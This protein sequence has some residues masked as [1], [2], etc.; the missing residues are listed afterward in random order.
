MSKLSER[1]MIAHVKIESWSAKCKD[2]KVTDKVHRDHNASAD[3]GAYQKRLLSK[4]ALAEITQI[5]NEAR[6]EHYART[7]PWE[8]GGMRLLS[9]AGFTAYAEAMKGYRRKFECAVEKFVSLY[10]DF[11]SDARARLNGMFNAA[12]YPDPDQIHKRFGFA[13][14]INPVPES[15]D[16]RVTLSDAQAAEIRADIEARTRDALADGMRDVWERVA[17]RVGHMAKK[18]NEF[19]PATEPG[20]KNQGV[21]RDSLVEN[22]RELVRLLP[23]LN[24]TGDA[25]LDAIAKR[26]EAEL[27]GHD[28]DT[29]RQS[30]NIRAG[31]AAK[32]EAI[33]KDVS[34]YLA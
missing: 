22:V 29:L 15:N 4:D 7:V 17:E 26:M 28:A 21:F 9:A 23:S 24:L 19:Q 11:V 25:K 16:F 13:V 20:Q 31:V 12:D 1:A 6:K 30:D 2:A 14:R 10:P 32:A 3:A 18:L 8:D 34:D 5:A 27:C 33:L